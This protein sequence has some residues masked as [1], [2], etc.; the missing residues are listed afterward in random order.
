MMTKPPFRVRIVHLRPSDIIMEPGPAAPA[1]GRGMTLPVGVDRDCAVPIVRR[2]RGGSEH[3]PGKENREAKTDG[4]GAH[5]RNKLM[6]ATRS[7]EVKP[8]V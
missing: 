8:G 3:L 6:L 2:T 4:S 1:I 7:R 5:H